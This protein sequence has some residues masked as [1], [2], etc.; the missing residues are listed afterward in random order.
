MPN[1]F[2]GFFG[3]DDNQTSGGSA[4]LTLRYGLGSFDRFERFR[5]KYF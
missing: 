4:Y 1:E 5:R 3:E 2:L